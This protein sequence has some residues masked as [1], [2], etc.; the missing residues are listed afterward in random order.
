MPRTERWGRAVLR[1]RERARYGGCVRRVPLLVAV[2]VV[3]FVSAVSALVG[4]P[5][6]AVGSVRSISRGRGVAPCMGR[7]R[8]ALGNWRVV[9]VVLE[10]HSYGDVV[11]ASPYLNR[12]ARECAL[13]TDDVAVSHPSLPNYLALTSGGTDGISSDCTSC[14]VHARSIFEQLHGDWR[15]YLESM[16]SPGFQGAFAGEYAKKHNPASYYTPIAAAYKTNAVPL[17]SVTT[18]SLARDLK[19][20]R[21]KR[22]SLIVPNLCHDEH[23]C[24]TT[25]WRSLASHLDPP[26]PRLLRLSQRAHSPVHHLRRGDRLRQPRLHRRRESVNQTRHDHPHSAQPLLTPQDKPTTPRP[27]L[28]RTHLRHDHELDHSEHR[29]STALNS[30]TRPTAPPV[31]LVAPLLVRENSPRKPSEESH[32]PTTG[33]Q[34]ATP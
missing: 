31:V 7:S 22:F 17:G 19:R 5:G 23:D 8:L 30:D 27:S 21:L 4:D 6:R 20:N 10:N 11:G 12:L 15:S 16:P 26:D 3:V 14:S 34:A 1:P 33:A 25:D 29:S 18:G 32:H 13:A 2:G 24:P 9:V 28:P